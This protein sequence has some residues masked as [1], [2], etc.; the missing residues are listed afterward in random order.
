MQSSAAVAG[1]ALIMLACVVGIPALALS[2][3]SWSETLKKLQDFRWPAILN[4]ASASTSASRDE[5]PRLA[6]AEP[7]K[8]PDTSN[9]ATCISCPVGQTPPKQ[10][11]LSAVVPA[12]Y[13]TPIDGVPNANATGVADMAADPFRF[14]QDRLRQ[15]GATYYLLESWGNQRQ[16]YRF[17][18]KMAI[19]GSPNYT[20]YFEAVHD[21]PLQAMRQVL[22]QV[23]Q[24]AQLG[25]KK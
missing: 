23:E 8:M 14:T 25:S 21:D 7:G 6:S 9:G 15:L 16:M 3:T 1:R 10:T 22:Q 4:L 20:R 17:Y 18:C 13:R 12:G 5:A 11:T 19:G 24:R 2:G